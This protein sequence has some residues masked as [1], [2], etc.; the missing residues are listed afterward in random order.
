MKD[1]NF[2]D[3]PQIKKVHFIGI[4]GI[5]M[6]GLAKIMINF[7]Y[8]V[9]GS[10]LKTFT[11]I[12]SLENLGVKI[13]IT[14]SEN[15]ISTND[16][17]IPNLIVYS[18]AIMNTNPELI[19]ARSLGIPCI[20]RAT[21]LGLV[22]KKYPYGLA[23]S[24]THGKTTTTAM[25]AMI[26]IESNL[27]PTVHIGGEL[28]AIGGNT[29]IGATKYFITEACEYVESFL[30]FHPFLAVLLNI[31]CDHLDYYKDICHINQSFLKF[32]SNVPKEGYVVACIDDENV[33]SLLDKIDCNIITYGIKNHHAMWRAENIKC[34]TFGCASF[35]L[36]KDKTEICKIDLNVPG[37]H[38]VSN[39]LAAIASCHTIGCSIEQIK[40]GL[41]KFIGTHRRFETK[42]IL[43]GIKV[44]D[45]YAHHPSEIVATL[46]AA[47]NCS[48]SKIWCVFQ[49]HTYTRTKSLLADFS[50]SF[51]DADTIIVSDIY[52]AREI[53]TGEI[54]S[55]LL[56]DK[57]NLTGKHAIYLSDFNL[58]VEYLRKN[59]SKDDIVI[60]MGA[61]DIYKVGEMFLDIG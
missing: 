9:T 55:N 51:Q 45:D 27:N 2:L 39:S 14:H 17:E 52:A 56:A 6:S 61:G 53:D 58:I 34:E 1:N 3:L 16:I 7:G 29:K 41:F 23:I 35:T 8:T 12:N 37:L 5:S 4:G 20:D 40:Q 46:S 33:T 54:H 38:N 13:Y 48:Q 15:N 49:P 24:G 59:A 32:V 26:A 50:T 28:E 25:I 36:W 19:K 60:T 57:I 42:G 18:A 22:M 11:S 43:R 47:K 21:L 44:I 30:K 31:E 10:D